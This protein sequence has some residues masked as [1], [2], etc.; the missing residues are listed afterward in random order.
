LRAWLAVCALIAGGSLVAAAF[1]GGQETTGAQ[2]QLLAWD[3]VHWTARPWTLWT[4]AW[5]SSSDGSLGANLLAFAILTVLGAVLGP[6][7]AA[8]I[9]LLAAWPL[10]TLAL[11][12]WPQVTYYAGLG[13]PVHAVAMVLAASLAGRGAF[14][15]LAPLALAAMGLKLI[16]ERAW[17]HPVAFDPS[18]GSN[19][20][21]AAHLSGA[22]AGAL[23]GLVARFVRR[24][25][26]T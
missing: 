9:A 21:Y 7:R 18:W 14:K 12:L 23:C 8:A 15:P 22:A 24:Q 13:E 6:G 4:A 19:V 11:L 5:A 2:L 10:G 25:T 26:P 16:A 3:P 17:L 1:P 20:V